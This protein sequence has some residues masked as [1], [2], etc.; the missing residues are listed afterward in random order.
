MPSK[1]QVRRHGLPVEPSCRPTGKRDGRL[2]DLDALE[3]PVNMLRL[4][5]GRRHCDPELR[6]LI[7][8]LTAQLD[9]AP[10]TTAGHLPVVDIAM[11]VD[12]T[13]H[14]YFSTIVTL[15]PPLGVDLQRLR[16]ELFHRND[17]RAGQIAV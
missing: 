7:D 13:V 4:V 17:T 12:G 9:V 6:A 16:I 5:F 2:V 8:E 3:P 14:R 15:G 10:A 11:L 1:R